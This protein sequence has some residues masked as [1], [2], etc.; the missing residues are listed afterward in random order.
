MSLHEV[1]HTKDEE[2]SNV[3][4]ISICLRLARILNTLHNLVPP[5]PHGSLTSQNIFFDLNFD[6]DAMKQ[7]KLYLAEIEL[8][9][10]KKYANMFASYRNISVWSSPECLKQPRKRL[11]PTPEMDVYSFGMLMWQIFYSCVPFDGDLKECTNYV[12][13]SDSRPKIDVAGVAEME[14][15][16]ASKLLDSSDGNV[17][18]SERLANIIRNCWQNEPRDRLKMGV[19]CEMLLEELKEELA[20]KETSILMEEMGEQM[21]SFNKINRTSS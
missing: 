11:D 8:N 12:V 7:Y 14:R 1:L 13:N 3:M 2:L 4:K 5:M 10:F 20:S 21:N 17:T 18:V 15:D 19:V 6:G 16:E 9:D